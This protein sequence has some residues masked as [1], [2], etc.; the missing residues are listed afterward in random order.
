MESPVKQ[1]WEQ[2]L[3]LL[4]TSEYFDGM[5]MSWIEKSDL[6]KIEGGVAYVSYRSVLANNLLQENKHSSKRHSL[7]YGAQVSISRSSLRKRWNR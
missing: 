2:T 4:R 7:R 1:Y 6:F 3:S 5:A